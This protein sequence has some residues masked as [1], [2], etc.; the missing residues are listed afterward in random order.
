[1]CGKVVVMWW[2]VKSVCWV[3]GLLGNV[4]INGY[5]EMYNRRIGVYVP[6]CVIGRVSECVAGHYVYGVNVAVSL[7]SVSA[8]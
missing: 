1:M 4:V 2:Y 7:A 3:R 8:M 6:V 5:V